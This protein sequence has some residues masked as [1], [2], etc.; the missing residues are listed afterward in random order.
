MS[1]RILL[2]DQDAARSA[3]LEQALHDAGHQVVARIKHGHNLLRELKECQPDIIIMDLEAPGRDTLEQMREISRDQP[4][5]I[6]LFS[7]KRDS[8]YIRQAVQAGVSAYVVDGLSQER[9]MPI[10]EV[11]IA[12]FRE[13]EALKRELQE[14]KTQLADRKVVDKAKGILMQRKGLSEDEAYQLLRKTAMSRNMRI[15]DVARTLL[16]LEG[17]TD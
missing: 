9:V 15:A 11:A 3:I 2:V 1:L 17:L 14:T 8:E 7:N 12:R 6:I 10:V 13:F 5:P 4:R 16:A